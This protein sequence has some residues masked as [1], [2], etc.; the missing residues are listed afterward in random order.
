MSD[1]IEP[2]PRSECVFM[3]RVGE[4]HYG[5]TIRAAVKA[6]ALL[7]HPFLLAARNRRLSREALCVFACEELF[8]S[9]AFP[10]MMAEVICRIPW[11]DETF[12]YP[13]IANMFEEA[14]GLEPTESHP[15]LLRKLACDLGVAAEAIRAKAPLAET[16]QYLDKLF[17]QCRDST[18]VEGLAAIGYGN[19]YLVLFEYPIL[20]RACRDNGCSD[21]VLKFFDVNV[22]ADVAHT[23]NI[24]SVI[25]SSCRTPEDWQLVRCATLR[26]LSARELF[27]DGLCRVVGIDVGGHSI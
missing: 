11:S 15:S 24:E 19:E 3:E 7:R 26:A 2:K 16:S 21:E 8:V 12:R 22:E 25:A 14:G 20:K 23:N 4:Q 1:T 6:H 9:M 13:L 10:T 17:G 5:R 18:Y 27:Y